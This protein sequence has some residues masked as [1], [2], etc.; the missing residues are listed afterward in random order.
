MV[1]E[2]W[3]WKKTVSSFVLGFFCVV[4]VGV[5]VGEIVFKEE[6]DRVWAEVDV[7]GWRWM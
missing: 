7:D 1:M 6:M 3:S 4:V 2:S 5:V